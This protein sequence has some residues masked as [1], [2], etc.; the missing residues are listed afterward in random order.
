MTTAGRPMTAHTAQVKTLCGVKPR[1]DEHHARHTFGAFD[2][3]PACGVSTD[4]VAD[5]D[6]VVQL[7]LV[8]EF[9]CQVTELDRTQRGRGMGDSP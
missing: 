9:H 1:I 5:D 7:E 2:G 4:G 8:D 3:Q 6:E